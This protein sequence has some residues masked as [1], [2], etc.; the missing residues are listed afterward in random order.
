MWIQLKISQN[1]RRHQS[2]SSKYKFCIIRRQVSYWYSLDLKIFDSDWKFLKFLAFDLTDE[3]DLLT[4][5]I[6]RP[7]IIDLSPWSLLH[8][9]MLN[10]LSWTLFLFSYVLPYWLSIRAQN[11]WLQLKILELFGFVFKIVWTQHY[12]ATILHS[13]GHVF[14]GFSLFSWF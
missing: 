7:K 6:T 1:P 13:S 11:F 4:R 8:I 12:F 3:C 5:S 2:S 10:C 14:R 9:L